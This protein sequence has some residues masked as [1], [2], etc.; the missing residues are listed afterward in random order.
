[1]LSSAAIAP[2]LAPL[3]VRAQEPTA[4]PIELTEEKEVVYG[5]V[6]GQQ[7][8]LDVRRPPE[9]EAP[10]PAV[11]LL[12]GGGLITGSRAQVSTPAVVLARQGYVTFSVDYRLFGWEDG[13]LAN[14]WPAQLH[15]VQRAVRW[16]RAHA[17]DYNVDPERIASYGHSSGGTLAVA[18]GA[19]ETRDDT[20]PAL[21]GISSRVNC[22][23]DLS[24]DMDLTIPYPDPMWD[25][26]NTAL[27][28]GTKE[29]KPEAW[30]DASPLYQVDENTAPCLVIHG[31]RD[32]VTPVE[33]SRTLIEA[34]H[35]AGVFAAYIELPDANHF[36][37][38]TW[39]TSGPWVETF[40]RL[41]LDPDV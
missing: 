9:R 27:I 1:V 36:G 6:D 5:E 13:S 33:H 24:G 35:A 23:V 17:A 31:A 3:G 32:D 25:E 18:L 34:L 20:D 30:Q 19:R 29:E 11:L 26:I 4:T 2:L 21:A 15:D 40:L 38:D 37:T 7:L 8:L 12:H 41:R 39:A 14:P 22:V 16:I 10:R 28:G